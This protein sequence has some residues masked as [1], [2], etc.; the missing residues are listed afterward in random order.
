MSSRVRG[1]RCPRWN[2]SDRPRAQYCRGTGMGGVYFPRYQRPT[3]TSTR[4]KLLGVDTM[5]G[6]GTLW[7]DHWEVED[8]HPRVGQEEGEVTMTPTMVE[9]MKEKRTNQLHPLESS[10]EG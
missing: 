2:M 4:M 3:S 1:R 8:D 5:G 7:E 6:N 10:G 9:M